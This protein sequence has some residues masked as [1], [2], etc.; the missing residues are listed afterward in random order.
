MRRN[1]IEAP[2]FVLGKDYTNAEM[3]AMADELLRQDARAEVC[4]DCGGYGNESEGVMLTHDAEGNELPLPLH[5]KLLTCGES[6][7]WYQGEGEVKGIGG[8]N[9][10]L[11]EE[12]F[13]SRRRREIYTTVGTP[14]PSIVSG[15]Y[16]RTHPQG[17]KT[18]SNEQR[19]KNG[20]S[21]YS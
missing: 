9:P 13:A 16:N 19:K 14:D 6:H 3:Q 15:I 5:L 18:N 11:F 21:F 12:H 4:R 10:I 1:R 7:T 17:R 2:E 20:A 8:K